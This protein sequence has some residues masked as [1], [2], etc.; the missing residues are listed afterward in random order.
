MENAVGDQVLVGIGTVAADISRLSL[1]F[2]H[3][4]DSLR[5]ERPLIRRKVFIF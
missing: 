4:R 2:E 5:L 1:S 3:A